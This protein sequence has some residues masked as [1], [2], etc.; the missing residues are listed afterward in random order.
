M[1]A[2]WKISGD[3]FL[4]SLAISVPLIAAVSTLL[5]GWRGTIGGF[6]FGVIVTPFLIGLIGFVI[7]VVQCALSGEQFPNH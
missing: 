7:L 5:C 6:V 1:S 3:V 2:T 4:L